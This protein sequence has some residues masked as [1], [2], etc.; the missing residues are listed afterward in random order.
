LNF[1]AAVHK[2]GKS[3]FSGREVNNDGWQGFPWSRSRI[4]NP[5]LYLGLEL[6][7]PFGFGHIRLAGCI[8]TRPRRG[9]TTLAQG[10]NPGE[11]ESVPTARE[12][13]RGS[14]TT[15]DTFS[16]NDFPHFK[17]IKHRYPRVSA[18]L[19]SALSAFNKNKVQQRLVVNFFTAKTQR[20]QRFSC[21]NRKDR[22]IGA[23]S[24]YY[25]DTLVYF[26]CDL[27]AFAVIFNANDHK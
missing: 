25:I 20:T 21:K 3:V 13:R 2:R 15:N 14:T 19:A 27:C 9:P 22:V 11:T 10:V 7:N 17:R 26:L 6:L 4:F 8:G 24:H 23:F 5:R 1:R 12:P 18:L 16:K